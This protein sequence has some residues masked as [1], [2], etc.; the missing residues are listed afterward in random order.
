MIIGI[1][2]CHTAKKQSV[3][4]FC[5]S[6]NDSYTSYYS[7]V[8]FQHAT[9]VKFDFNTIHLLYQEIID[10][11]TSLVHDALR[12]FFSKNKKLPDRIIVFRDGVGEGQL[13]A[14]NEHESNST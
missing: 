10:K 12:T 4:G 7:R 1:D 3:V 11:L 14:V 13:A 9:Q 2:V 5:A 8:T 6:L